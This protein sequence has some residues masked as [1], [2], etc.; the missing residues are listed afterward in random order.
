MNLLLRADQYATDVPLCAG[1]RVWIIAGLAGPAAHA[2]VRGAIAPRGATVR[3]AQHPREGYWS[4]Q[5]ASVADSRGLTVAFG[6]IILEPAS[7]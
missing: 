3:A 4:R 2:S 6:R 5:P 7:A 1:F